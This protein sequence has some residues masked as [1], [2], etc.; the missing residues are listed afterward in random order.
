MIYLRNLQSTKKYTP[1]KVV[2]C[3][4]PVHKQLTSCCKDCIAHSIIYSVNNLIFAIII[5]LI[6]K[7][8]TVV[9]CKSI[10]LFITKILCCVLSKFRVIQL[11]LLCTH[12]VISSR[13]TLCYMQLYLPYRVVVNSSI[14]NVPMVDK[15]VRRE[16]HFYLVSCNNLKLPRSTGQFFDINYKNQLSCMH[17]YNN[18]YKQILL[19]ML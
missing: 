7:W 9:V 18:K 15:I 14:L 19:Q 11:N 2:A 10:L 12:L 13:L 8:N 6:G 1:A 3:L 17:K 16:V 4:A 5:L